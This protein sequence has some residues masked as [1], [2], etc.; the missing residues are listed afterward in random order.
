VIVRPASPADLAAIRELD[1]E[2]F[3]VDA[4]S[5]T[6]WEGE[7]NHVQTTRHLVVAV[8]ATRVIGFAVLSTVADVA[9]LHRIAVV[10]DRRRRGIGRALVEALIAEARRRRCGR[11]LLEVEAG[12]AAGLALYGR[13]DFVQ[14]AR[15][16]SYYGPGRHALVL[17]LRLD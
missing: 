10:P 6:A 3:G 2:T 14:I 4:W 7:W 17:E 5:E 16:R 13:L 9:D 11:M 12:N 1:A 8:E 15:R